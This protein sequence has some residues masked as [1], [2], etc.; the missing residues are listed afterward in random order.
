G[1]NMGDYFGHWLEIG[2]RLKQ[3]PKVFRVNWFNRDDAGR[4]IWP[5][6]GDNLRVL[7][8]MIERCHDRGGAV[9]TAIGVIPSKGAPDTAGLTLS[10]A[11]MDRLLAVDHEGWL[12]ALR[13]QEEFFA[14]FG[15]RMPQEMHLEHEALRRRL[16][17]T[18]SGAES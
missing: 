15:P 8:W 4:F 11:E 1:Y 14:Q 3:P 7:Q 18:H 9:E 12:R 5:G 17:G 2:R 13:T 10:D 16:E 6:F